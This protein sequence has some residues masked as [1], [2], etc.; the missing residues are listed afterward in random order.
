MRRAWATG[1]SSATEG[2]FT[3]RSVLSLRSVTA[4][5]HMVVVS[6]GHG[7]CWSER[8]RALQHEAVC[9]DFCDAVPRRSVWSR[10]GCK[11]CE[12]CACESKC[13]T[14]NARHGVKTLALSAAA[15][16]EA[17]QNISSAVTAGSPLPLT[18]VMEVLDSVAAAIEDAMLPTWKYSQTQYFFTKLGDISTEP[19]SDH[20]VCSRLGPA[21]TRVVQR[22]VR[23]H[24]IAKRE[25]FECTRCVDPIGC[26]HE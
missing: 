13:C 4:M 15:F 19:G 9:K 24:A 14:A 2:R 8:S 1:D 12:W 22:V 26:R 17:Q 11:F 6:A 25:C 7:E 21:H 3:F 10:R 5:L 23:C 20:R 18:T 16:D